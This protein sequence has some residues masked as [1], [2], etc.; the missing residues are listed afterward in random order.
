M[1][2]GNTNVI[3]K[4]FARQVYYSTTAVV[5][6]IPKKGTTLKLKINENILRKGTL[7]VR[8]LSRS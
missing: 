8:F 3:K 4:Q 2:K 6:E 7:I 5:V 1:S